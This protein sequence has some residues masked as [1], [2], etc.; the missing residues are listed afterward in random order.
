MNGQNKDDINIEKERIDGIEE[1]IK[2]NAQKILKNLDDALLNTG[3][4]L[5]F[6]L[7]GYDKDKDKMVIHN[8]ALAREEKRIVEA[9]VHMVEV[10]VEFLREPYVV[11]AFQQPDVIPTRLTSLGTHWEYFSV[12]FA[13]YTST[14]ERL[15]VLSS[16]NASASIPM[17]QNCC[18]L[19]KG[20]CEVE[21]NI[22]TKNEWQL[23]GSKHPDGIVGHVYD[24]LLGYQVKCLQEG[25]VKPGEGSIAEEF[26]IEFRE[27]T[28]KLQKRANDLWIDSNDLWGKAKNDDPS[29]VAEVINNIEKALDLLS[30]DTVEDSSLK[31]MNDVKR[32][33]EELPSL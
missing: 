14:A 20:V 11:S 7:T 16:Y 5:F 2:E 10:L 6:N 28:N 15:A 3:N 29:Q 9:T 8:S 17:I 30:K 25:I 23:S 1:Q 12:G 21:T 26:K 31:V 18:D 4:A 13:R 24:I 19:V 22:I 32:F 33:L 27:R